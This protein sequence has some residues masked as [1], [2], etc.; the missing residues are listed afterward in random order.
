[1]TVSAQPSIRM[2]VNFYVCLG[3][4]LTVIATSLL[5]DLLSFRASTI[6][7]AFALSLIAYVLFYIRGLAPLWTEHGMGLLASAVLT[8]FTFFGAPDF[9]IVVV[10]AVVPAFAFLCYSPL[11]A[12][13][14]TG[15]LFLVMIYALFIG[16]TIP[17]SSVPERVRMGL[18]A[19]YLLQSVICGVSTYVRSYYEEQLSI[20]NQK[21]DTLERMIPFCM[22]CK[23]VRYDDDWLTIEAYLGKVGDIKVTHGFCPDCYEKRMNEFSE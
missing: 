13:I 18:L 19:A 22:D 20:A 21:I 9:G 5:S 1:M 4:S 14:W 10:F 2:R 17:Q 7:T 12:S 8:Y 16:D 3:F 15:L 11:G 23:V 6:S